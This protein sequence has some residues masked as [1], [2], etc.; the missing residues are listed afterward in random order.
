[1]SSALIGYTGF[2]GSNL[3]EYG[4][5]ESLYSSK[6]IKDIVGKKFDHVICAGLSGVKWRA[7]KDPETDLK[8]VQLL[9]DCLRQI[10]ADRF[11]LISSIDVY[12]KFEGVNE[13]VPASMTHHP[14]GVHR[15]LFENFIIKNFKN[16]RVLRLP[17]VFGQN[18]KKNYIF[19]LINENNLHNICVK[20]HVQF[21][22]VTDLGN[23]IDRAW[24]S[25]SGVR[26]LATEPLYLSMIINKYFPS[27]MDLCTSSNIFSTNMVTKC[28]S[29]G[30]LYDRHNILDKIGK[31]LESEV[32]NIKYSVE[33]SP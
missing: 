17:I 6:N 7:N 24:L 8:S 16:H 2:I 21:Y 28:A 20:N 1:M 18:F 10:S 15:A 30:Y 33:T 4:S 23:D 29:S 9:M 22:D 25:K 27:I 11:T 12:D 14:Y 31:M 19:D 13:D 26:N 3:L 5:Y 32:F